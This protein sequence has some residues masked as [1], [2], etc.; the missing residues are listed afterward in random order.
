MSTS[1]KKDIEQ[2]SWKVR[3][4]DVLRMAE[5]VKDER[6]FLYKWNGHFHDMVRAADLVPDL[7]MRVEIKVLDGPYPWIG[8][9]PEKYQLAAETGSLYL[10]PL[11]GGG[12]QL[13]IRDQRADEK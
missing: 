8:D 9:V 11:E 4:F 2:E 3:P 6:V 1:M 5:G 12:F 10:I 13:E 7:G